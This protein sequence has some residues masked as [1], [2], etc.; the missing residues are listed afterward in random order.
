M[1]DHGHDKYDLRLCCEVGTK[2]VYEFGSK[3]ER[4]TI[5]TDTVLKMI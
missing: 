3:P 2:S 5:Q 1:S 4:L